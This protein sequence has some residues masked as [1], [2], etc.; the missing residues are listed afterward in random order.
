MKDYQ[1]DINTVEGYLVGELDAVVIFA[2]DELNAYWRNGHPTVSICTKQSKRL[3]F[4]ALLHEAGHAILRSKDNYEI[5]FPYGQKHKNKSISR[6]V[7]VIREEV[8]AWEEGRELATD[9]GIGI[10]EKLWHNF[11]KK[12]LFDYVRWANDPK[13][14]NDSRQ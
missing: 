3:Q 13:T 11:I 14:F 10:D 12:N 2:D 6:R 7:D 8:M 1:E 5:K 9:L 4:Y